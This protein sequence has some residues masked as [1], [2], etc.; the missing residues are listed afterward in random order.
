MTLKEMRPIESRPRKSTEGR[1]GMKKPRKLTK[2]TKERRQDQPQK[3]PQLRPSLDSQSQTS[4]T[5]LALSPPIPTPRVP[6]L[7]WVFRQRRLQIRIV[8][9]AKLRTDIL[10]HSE[11]QSHIARAIL[12]PTDKVAVC[13]I[14]IHGHQRVDVDVRES[15][16]R[17]VGGLKRVR[18]GSRGWHR[19]GD[20]CEGIGEGCWW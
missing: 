15:R 17:G 20:W 1:C 4:K 13:K 3:K 8:R 7:V 5:M 10:R 12:G 2:E 19:Y 14:D 18:E 6:N 9:S 11:T 16:G